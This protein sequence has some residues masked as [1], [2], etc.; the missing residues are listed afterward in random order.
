MS[1]Q[2][3]GCEVDRVNR[4]ELM[5]VPQRRPRDGDCLLQ[6]GRRLGVSPLQTQNARDA[7][8]RYRDGRVLV[9][10]RLAMDFQCLSKQ[11]ERRGEV[12]FRCRDQTEVVQ[13]HARVRVI[14][15][16]GF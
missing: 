16:R 9:A 5:I 11:R 15:R 1:G 2:L 14:R 7:V 8:E 13:R 12:A 6:R 10:I 4:D 3:D